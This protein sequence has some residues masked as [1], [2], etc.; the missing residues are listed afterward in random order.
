MKTAHHQ[1]AG[2]QRW[3]LRELWAHQTHKEM[4]GSWYHRELSPNQL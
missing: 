2:L 4:V 3:G 1:L